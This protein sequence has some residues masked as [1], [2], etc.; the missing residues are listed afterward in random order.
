MSRKPVNRRSTAPLHRAC[1]PSQVIERLAQIH[2]LLHDD[3]SVNYSAF[4]QRTGIPISSVSRIH[5]GIQWREAAGGTVEIDTTRW[6]LSSNTITKLVRAFNI[7]HEEADGTVE[8]PLDTPSRN[9]RA[10]LRH[11]AVNPAELELVFAI[12]ALS[13]QSQAD[14]RQLV[15]L[16]AELEAIDKPA[17]IQTDAERLKAAHAMLG[18]LL[19]SGTSAPPAERTPQRKGKASQ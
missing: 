18:A 5:R 8:I 17:P 11:G 6:A 7:S 9:R 10:K 1:T 14:V 16:R 3:G 19:G 4:G 13:P 2:G 15:K 12:R